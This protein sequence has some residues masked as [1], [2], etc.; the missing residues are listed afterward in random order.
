[1]RGKN[2]WVF[3]SLIL[4]AI[5]LESSFAQEGETYEQEYD[6]YQKAQAET[7]SSR[8]KALCL[9]FVET[10]KKSQL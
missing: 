2:C 10:F 6:L 9:E 7:D 1:M 3:L 4:L 5:S 8:Q